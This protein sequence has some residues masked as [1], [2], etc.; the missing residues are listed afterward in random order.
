MAS[1]S[2]F[3]RLT[4]HDSVAAMMEQGHGGLYAHVGGESMPA[5]RSTIHWLTRPRGIQWQPAIAAA[6]AGV[7]RRTGRRA[8][9]RSY[10]YGGYYHY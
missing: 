9:R 10:Y 7:A 5:P 2:I 1:C 4:P 8:Y 6:P 3:S